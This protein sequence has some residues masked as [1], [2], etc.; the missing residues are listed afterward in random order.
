MP[1]HRLP[2]SRTRYPNQIQIGV[3]RRATLLSRPCA[4]DPGS[5]PAGISAVRGT[6]MPPAAAGFPGGFCC[7]RQLVQ[8]IRQRLGVHQA[9]LHC[10]LQQG[11][12]RDRR[13]QC[14]G[15]PR[16]VIRLS[17][18]SRSSWLYSLTRA[19]AGQSSARSVGSHH[20]SDR[21]QTKIICRTRHDADPDPT[22]R[23]PANSNRTLP[24]APNK[25]SAGAAGD[26]PRIQRFGI[27]KSKMASVCS[28]ADSKR[29]NRMS[30]W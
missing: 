29:A 6:K 21:S 15:R 17:S 30:R 3:H 28:R 27:N 24:D 10:D 22:R 18:V 8:Q 19:S 1:E 16:M 4:V 9:M 5:Q 11:A 23:V 2:W 25:K 13:R 7:L 12:V 14:L 26:G 20:G